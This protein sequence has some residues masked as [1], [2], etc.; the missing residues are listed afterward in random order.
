MRAWGIVLLVV[1]V[2]LTLAVTIATLASLPT[3][4]FKDMWFQSVTTRLP[5]VFG[6]L[7]SVVSALA[8][9]AG[10]LHRDKLETLLPL[11]LAFLAGLLLLSQNW[12]MSLAFA[13]LGVAALL[14]DWFRRPTPPASNESPTAPV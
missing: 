2:F 7:V 4:A 10:A 14:K 3:G 1:G 5:Q 12:L 6:I 9:L 8:L 13:L 11:A